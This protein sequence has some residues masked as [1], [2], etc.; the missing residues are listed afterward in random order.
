MCIDV[1]RAVGER[2]ALCIELALRAARQV[3]GLFF[4]Y[5]YYY[6]LFLHR[7]CEASAPWGRRRLRPP[8]LPSLYS[9]G[10]YSYGVHS[11]GLY[12]YGVY[13]HGVHSYGLYSYGLY[14]YRL[15]LP[16]TKPMTVV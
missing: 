16:F 13:N 5:C 3:L 7:K 4:Y 2:K 6:C 10:L 9:Y 12:S 15:Y 14:S 1:R 8:R 11:Y